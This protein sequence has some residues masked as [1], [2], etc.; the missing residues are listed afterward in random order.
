MKLDE[1]ADDLCLTQHLRYGQNQISSG[2]TFAQL[3]AQVHTDNIGRQEINWLAEHG[4]FG[5]DTAHTP[6]NDAE[7]IDHRCVRVSADQTI[8]IINVMLPPD[9]FREILE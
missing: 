4:G 7:P 3:A 5:F 9:A 1:L 2:N 8:G 6:T